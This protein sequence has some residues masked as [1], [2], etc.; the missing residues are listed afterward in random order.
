MAAQAARV[1][2]MLPHYGV[3]NET[4]MSE[5]RKAI[6]DWLDIPITEE[7]TQDARG[8][9]TFIAPHWDRLKAAI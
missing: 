2:M 6:A 3:Y 5:L 8:W 1:L 4:G 9:E 7:Q